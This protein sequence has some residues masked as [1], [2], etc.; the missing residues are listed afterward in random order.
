MERRRGNTLVELMAV[1]SILSV[2]AA[3][4]LLRPDSGQDQQLESAAQELVAAVSFARSEAMRT[5]DAIGVH[6][7][8]SAARVR[9][10]RIDPGAT[11]SGPSGPTTNGVVY[12]VRNPFTGHLYTIDLADSALRPDLELTA[13][14]FFAGACTQASLILF[15]GDATPRCTDPTSVVLDAADFGLG[16]SNRVAIVD[17]SGL[18][19]RAALR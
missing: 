10:F 5:G 6:I 11:P 13:N 17:L 12:D 18:T 3:I 8:P 2:L 7:E 4:V 1:A 9:L 19:G 16:L 14:L 15:E